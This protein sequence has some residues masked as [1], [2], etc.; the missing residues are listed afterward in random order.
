MSSE[1]N[2]ISFNKVYTENG[3][4]DKVYAKTEFNDANYQKFIDYVANETGVDRERFNSSFEIDS[5]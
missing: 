4:A 5:D 3:F 1:A 2:R